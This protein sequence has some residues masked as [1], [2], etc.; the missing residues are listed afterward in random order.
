MAGSFAR[1]Y[2][3]LPSIIWMETVWLIHR[4]DKWI[5]ITDKDGYIGDIFRFDIVLYIYVC[6]CK[7]D[8]FQYISETINL[9]MFFYG[10]HL[11]IFLISPKLISFHTCKIIFF[12]FYFQLKD[13]I[14]WWG[15]VFLQVKPEL[16]KIKYFECF[17][18]FI[19]FLIL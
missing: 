15:G 9:F 14:L 13:F 17:I 10:N 11:F 7:R 18:I 3:S 12:I 16:I 4:I 6:V 2:G 19:V 1:F 5:N 8:F